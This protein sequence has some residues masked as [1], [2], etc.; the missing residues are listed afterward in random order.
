[1]R[2]ALLFAVA[3]VLTSSVSALP[4]DGLAQGKAQPPRE[5]FQPLPATTE[6]P[7]IKAQ[8]QEAEQAMKGLNQGRLTKQQLRQRLL[9]HPNPKIRAKAQQAAKR[10]PGTLQPANPE[11]PEIKALRQE[12]EQ[13]MKGINQGRL[14]KQQLRQMLL[15][16]SNLHIREKAQEAQRVKQQPRGGLDSQDFF[17]SLSSLWTFLNPWTATE[18]L[19]QGS[20]AVTLTADARSSSNPP[21]YLHLHGVA[22][23]TFMAS[24]GNPE[25]TTYTLSNWNGSPVGLTIKKPNAFL[26][27]WLPR[28]GWYLIDFYGYGKPKATLR[29]KAQGNP[30]L[31]SWNMTSSST[32]YNHFATLEYLQQGSHIFYLII[33]KF[34]LQFFEVSVEEF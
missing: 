16:H 8:Q 29:K 6:P 13:A 15:N 10:M 23:R 14:S 30:V 34:E 4:S 18:A 31:E 3:L 7:E 21:A 32:F 25:R 11:P 1:M 17:A 12:A 20:Y 27:V 24:M 2:R 5:R 26:V 9:N 22:T 33:D 28:T 19:A